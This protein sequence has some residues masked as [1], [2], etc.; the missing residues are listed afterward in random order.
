LRKATR[1]FVK[2][3]CPSIRMEQLGSRFHENL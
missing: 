3:V 2:S 1:S